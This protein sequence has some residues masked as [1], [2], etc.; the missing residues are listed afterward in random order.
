MLTVTTFSV[1]G[2]DAVDG[3]M[4]VAVVGVAV[5]RIDRLVLPEAHLGEEH[6]NGL[7]RLGARRLLTLSPAQDPVLHGLRAATG[8]L[9]EVDHLLHLTVVVDV[10]E[11]QGA[12]VLDLLAVAAGRHAGDVVDQG[13]HVRGLALGRRGLR[14]ADLLDD[15]R[16]PLVPAGE[17]VDRRA[18]RGEGGRR[19]LAVGA[20]AV[21]VNLLEQ[22]A[23][24][25]QLADRRGIGARHDGAT[26]GAR[27]GSTRRR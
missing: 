23:E 18:K 26:E 1:V 27:A 5:K 13:A 24:P 14:R 21:E 20:A 6:P 12:A 8:D 3:D 15:H 7:V 11:V 4:D 2:V 19:L 9:G 16:A 22:A 17:P 25:A 10:E